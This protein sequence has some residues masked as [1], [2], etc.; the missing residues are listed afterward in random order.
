[1]NITGPKVFFY[2]SPCRV[3]R[4][5][6][7]DLEPALASALEARY[8]RLGY[9]GE[10]FACMAHQPEALKSFVEFTELAKAPLDK[11]II[12]VIALTLA[13]ESGNLYERNQHERLSI[14][15]GFSP[16]WIRQIQKLDPD[17]VAPEDKL[18]QRWT[19][20]VA[21]RCYAEAAPLF[22]AVTEE[23]GVTTAIA[24]LMIAARYIAHSAMVQ[25]LGLNPPVPSI[26]E[27]G[28]AAA[29]RRV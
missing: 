18:I 6:F 11:R 25:T 28:F 24:A 20:A 10:F 5:Q 3:P 19:L 15:N 9:L 12:E 21:R 17:G 26:F 14:R 13:T 7:K 8:Q 4:I 16:D 2:M 27:D 22:Q 1:M 23:L 29:A